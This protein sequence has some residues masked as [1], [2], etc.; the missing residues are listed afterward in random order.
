MRIVALGSTMR[1]WMRL[2]LLSHSPQQ[3][4]SVTLLPALHLH[5]PA[6]LFLLLLLIR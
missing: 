3:S 1:E 2:K 6:L 5:L 4:L